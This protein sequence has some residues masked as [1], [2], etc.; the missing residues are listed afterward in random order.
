[1]T[2]NCQVKKLHFTV[3]GEFIT[4]HARDRV[5][6]GNWED[7]IRF[8]KT[9]IMGFGYDNIIDI[10]S[11]AS[12]LTGDSNGPK[13]VSIEKRTDSKYVAKLD[14]LYGHYF[15]ISRQWYVPYQYITS[16]GPPDMSEFNIDVQYSK[17]SEVFKGRALFYCQYPGDKMFY[18]KCPDG[19]YH[20]V[21]FKKVSEPPVWMEIDK[22]PQQSLDATRHIRKS[23]FHECYPDY[24]FSKYHDTG[25]GRSK[26]GYDQVIEEKPAEK[27]EPVKPPDTDT[28]LK[29]QC[30]WV[31]PTG[32]F[33]GCE[34]GGH[35]FLAE[36]IVETIIGLTDGSCEETE[37][38]KRG[39]L[40]IGVGGHVPYFLVGGLRE[41]KD[42]TQSQCDTVW[43]WCKQH[44]V[45]FP[46]G[47]FYKF[48][49]EKD[50]NDE[51]V[52]EKPTKR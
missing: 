26:F 40:K 39:W 15:R 2:T 24:D 5:L 27:K 30:G 32:E 33:Y 23:G 51:P 12:R 43:D 35:I 37:L 44:S 29:S 52:T 34:Y 9:S 14:E 28:E 20:V 50:D 36:Q 31:S 19:E 45:S 18:L 46:K 10:L 47:T 6:E 16:Y 49:D 4:E 8:L 48:F 7:A 13:Y 22:T 38:E 17:G 3:T 1:M 21:T 11:G 41:R 25:K 42:P